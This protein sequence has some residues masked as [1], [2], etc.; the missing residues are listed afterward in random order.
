MTSPGSSSRLSTFS[1]LTKRPR[2]W[3]RSVRGNDFEDGL[4][5]D[6]SR[7]GHCGGLLPDCSTREGKSGRLTITSP[8][9]SLLEAW[10]TLG[11]KKPSEQQVSRGEVRISWDRY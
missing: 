8:T 11:F 5:N 2:R 3:P 9:P 1:P 4:G 7:V 6:G 10:Q